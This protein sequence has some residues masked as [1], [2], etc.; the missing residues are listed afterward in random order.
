MRALAAKV[1]KSGLGKVRVT[2]HCPVWLTLLISCPD[3]YGRWAS[4]VHRFECPVSF[5]FLGLIL[6]VRLCMTALASRACV[7]LCVVYY[8]VQGDLKEGIQEWERQI[9]AAAGAEAEGGDGGE[10][11][12][13][14]PAIAADS[15]T[16]IA[17][18]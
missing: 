17:V 13:P 15:R 1:R 11:G 12:E 10:E 18:A 14:E 8:W 2:H 6:H 16:A 5:C 4:A 3:V 9:L 7:C